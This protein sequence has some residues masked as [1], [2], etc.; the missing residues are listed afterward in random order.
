[1]NYERSIQWLYDLQF[2]GMKLGLDN[3]LALMEELGNP[4]ERLK[5]I[6]VAGTNGKGSVCAFLTSVL[7]EAG[8]KVGTYTSPHLREFGERICING[9]P[10][11]KDEVVRSTSI[12]KPVVERL[13]KDDVKCTFF[14]TATA[15]ALHHFAKRK[16]DFAV[17]EVGMGGRLDSTNV[18][19]PLVSVITNIGLEHTQHLCDSISKIAS[20]KAGII[21]NG[22]PVICGVKKT[23]ALRI[24]EGQCKRMSAPLTI[25]QD[26]VE[27]EIISADLY[28]STVSFKIG[29]QCLEECRI[30]LAGSHQIENAATAVAVVEVLKDQG[31][32]IENDILKSG[33][34]K[35]HWGG[36]L[37]VVGTSPL[38]IVDTSHNKFG[39]ETLA[40]FV[41]E[42]LK[43][44]RVIAVV[45]MLEDKDHTGFMKAMKPVFDELILTEPGY[46]RKMEAEQLAKIAG[47]GAV[48]KGVGKAVSR[49]L[50]LAKEDGVILITGSIFT[51][52]DALAFLDS[53]KVEEVMNILPELYPI[54]AFPGREVGENETTLGKRTGDAFN[55][56]ISTILS[57]RTRDE[58]TH[59]ASEA[60][61]SKYNTPEKLAGADITEVEK[62]IRPAGF[63]RNKARMITEVSKVLID[64]HGSEVPEELDALL[65]LPGVSRKTANCVLVYGF[66]KPAMPVDTHVHRISNLLGLIIT[67]EPEH[68]EF[69]LMELIPE[70]YWLDINRLLVRHGQKVCKPI[71]PQCGEC[72]VSHVCDFGIYKLRLEVQ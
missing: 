7:K 12:I 45:G 10:M 50:E 69:A 22:R 56:L 13:A 62:L 48:V 2:F 9:F 47:N 60:L 34:E 66:R 39:A 29:K 27:P 28:G 61:F 67:K 46:H 18:V 5:V 8:Y 19:K 31:F 64:R 40:A 59:V 58:N 24:I 51:A 55:V 36:R 71:G 21:K 37:Q 72:P 38:V 70:K 35:T 11:T 16:V 49:A 3:T 1:M 41:N 65:K 17:V 63:Y 43:G 6:H 32:A 25:T 4:H 54:G 33:L 14:E 20:E 68:S 42:Q 53:R 15:M 52:S 57:Q 23:E 30:N 26:V 44:K